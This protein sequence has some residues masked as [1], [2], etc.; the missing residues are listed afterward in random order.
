MRRLKSGLLAKSDIESYFGAI[1][2]AQV[3]VDRCSCMIG[4]QGKPARQNFCLLNSLPMNLEQI[5]QRMDLKRLLEC[6]NGPIERMSANLESIKDDFECKLLKSTSESQLMSLSIKENGSSTLDISRPYIQ[7]HEQ[8]KREVL[9][10]TGQWLLSD[11]VFKR[12]KNESVSSILWLHGIPGSG[13][14]KL[15]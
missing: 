2:T 14:S 6:M 9:Q 11:P 10:G 7:Y 13:K 15:V 12:W 3:T 8:A 4:M 5:N 1:A